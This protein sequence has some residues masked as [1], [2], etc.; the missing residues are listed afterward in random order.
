M[1]TH[2]NTIN[3]IEIKL[4]FL[5]MVT[6]LHNSFHDLSHNERSNTEVIYL[7]SI[8]LSC[9]INDWCTVVIQNSCTSF[10]NEDIYIFL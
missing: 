5:S 9:K 7:S 2:T 4:K 10:T 8:E 6:E 1:S 3:L